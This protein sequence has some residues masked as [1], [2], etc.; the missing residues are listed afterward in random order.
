MDYMLDLTPFICPIPLFM[1]RKALASLQPSETLII[2][3]ANQSTLNDML[4]LCQ[5]HHYRLLHLQQIDDISYQLTLQ[6]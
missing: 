3:I 2:R 5:Q 6:K 4:L 1:A